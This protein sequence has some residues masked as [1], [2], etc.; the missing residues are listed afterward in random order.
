MIDRAELLALLAARFRRVRGL[1]NREDAKHQRG[2]SKKS[3]RH[4]AL[5]GC[6]KDPIKPLDRCGFRFRAPMAQPRS[7]RRHRRVKGNLSADEALS[8]RTKA[9]TW[10]FLLP[11]VYA[12]QQC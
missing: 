4:D 3:G 11:L 10:A 8:G 1:R 2:Y 9:P 7:T 6:C 5:L 12:E